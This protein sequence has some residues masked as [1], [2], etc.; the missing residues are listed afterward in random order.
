MMKKLIVALLITALVA[1]AVAEARRGGGGHGGHGY[2]HS[3][4]YRG[5]WGWSNSWFFPTLF[6]GAMLYNMNQPSTVYVTPP[7][8]AMTYVAPQT[9]Q[10]WYWCA[11]ANAYYPYAQTCPGGWQAVPAT[12]PP[13]AVQ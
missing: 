8:P 11:G 5:G 13:A 12:P 4:Y 1:P 3:H 6:T 10:Y 7:T 2:S 9:T